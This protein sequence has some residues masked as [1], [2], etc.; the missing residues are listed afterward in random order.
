MNHTA[1]EEN[2]FMLAEALVGLAI[3]AMMA[4]LVFSSVWQL[5]QTTLAAGGRREAMLLARSIMAASTAPTGIAPISPHGIDH[6]LAWDVAI[7]PRSGGTTGIADEGLRVE[8]VTVRVT[9][10]ANA[11]IL[12]RLDGLR[13][14]P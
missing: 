14:T 10:S 7:T 11:H 12:A 9:D 13:V 6:G 5:G 2:G 8:A 4:G 1:T 3:V